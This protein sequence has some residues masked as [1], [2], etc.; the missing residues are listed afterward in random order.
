MPNSLLKALES[1]SILSV[2]ADLSLHHNLVPKCFIDK[3]DSLHEVMH[4]Q[5]PGVC[6]TAQVDINGLQDVLFQ[7]LEDTQSVNEVSI[8]LETLKSKNV[9]DIIL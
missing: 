2:T 4:V 8:F 6:A 3:I 1:G 5:D 7:L 9:S